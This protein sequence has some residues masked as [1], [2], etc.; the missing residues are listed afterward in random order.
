[1]LDRLR[2][3]CRYTTPVV[4]E[5]GKNKAQGSTSNTMMTTTFNISTLLFT[6]GVACPAVSWKH[7]LNMLR[8]HG[9]DLI[10]KE[11]GGYP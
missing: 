9:F 2:N 7:N 10:K 3:L 11:G 8:F 1:M 5:L 6:E 4:K